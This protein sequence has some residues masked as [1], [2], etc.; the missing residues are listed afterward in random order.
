MFRRRMMM[1]FEVN[2][3]LPIGIDLS[4]IFGTTTGV[5]LDANGKLY[6][7]AP[8]IASKYIPANSDYKFEVKTTCSSWQ[9]LAFYDSQKVFIPPTSSLGKF[10]GGTFQFGKGTNIEIPKNAKFFIVMLKGQDGEEYY[11]KRIE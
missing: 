1:N 2:D 8:G 5:Q 4:T 3:E 6:V 9:K 11:I 10:G 7:W